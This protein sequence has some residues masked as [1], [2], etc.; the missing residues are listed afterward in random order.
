[1]LKFWQ[2]IKVGLCC[3]LLAGCETTLANKTPE[4]EDPRSE[5]VSVPA[6]Q[7][8]PSTQ[9]PP[10]Q[11]SPTTPAVQ[12][13]AP[14][15]IRS[16][17]TIT[18]DPPG[19]GVYRELGELVGSTPLT[20]EFQFERLTRLTF[21]QRGYVIKSVVLEPKDGEHQLHVVLERDIR[22]RP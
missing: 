22:A 14:K 20:I 3:V 11:I 13:N 9:E 6:P 1:M 21:L 4:P 10:T 7:N 5:P 12:N 18:S 19:V 15:R 17:Y 8:G 2:K 16:I